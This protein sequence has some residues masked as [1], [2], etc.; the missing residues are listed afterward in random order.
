MSLV[1]VDRN[2]RPHV[3]VITLN[4]PERLNSMSF[5]LVE[6][7]YEA[8]D[9][10]SRDNDSWVVVLTGAGRGFVSSSRAVPPDGP[11]HR[12]AISSASTTTTGSSRASSISEDTDRPSA[13]ARRTSVVRFGLPFAP[14]NATSAPLLT[15]ARAA[16]ASSD[17]PATERA[18]RTLR[19]MVSKGASCIIGHQSVR[20]G[21]FDDRRAAPVLRSVSLTRAAFLVNLD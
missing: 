5:P 13:S 17:K 8:L 1:L 21:R 18:E 19:A 12:G 15:S 9:E 14:S 11:V 4:K 6:A 16:R 20:Y 7:L 2:V 3:S 10:V